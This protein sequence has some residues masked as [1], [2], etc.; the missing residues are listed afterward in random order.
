MIR[1]LILF[2]LLAFPVLAERDIAKD[3]IAPLLDPAKVATLKGD[4]P[5]NERMYRVLG[6]LETARQA[7]GDVSKVI[8]SAQAAAGYGG[9][10]GAN[11]D[12]LAIVWNRN[13]LEKFGCF[14]PDGL[15]KLKKGGSP[16][17]RIGDHAGD[18]IALDHV[19]PRAVVP[20]LEARFYSFAVG[21]ISR[22]RTDFKNQ[23]VRLTE[24]RCS[25]VLILLVLNGAAG[26]I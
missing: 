1:C 23:A 3:I 18:G 26:R 7:G 2:F 4:R 5:A 13:I 24:P 21:S 8:D 10:L 15:A 6:W 19:L 17:I 12:K 22:L 9:T 14:T 16:K 20:E 11:A 25:K